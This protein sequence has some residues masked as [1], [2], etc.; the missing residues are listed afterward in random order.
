[1]STASFTRSEW[2]ALS[3]RDRIRA[4][5]DTLDHV[6]QVP[7]PKF[8]VG[9]IA[10]SEKAID[11][12]NTDLGNALQQEEPRVGSAVDE[13]QPSRRASVVDIWRKRESAP[14]KPAPRTTP[15]MEKATIFDNKSPFDSATF[16]DEKKEDELEYV[17]AQQYAMSIKDVWKER[18][19]VSSSSI[20]DVIKVQTPPWQMKALNHSLPTTGNVTPAP[21]PTE[22]S[23]TLQS[24]NAP[25]TPIAKRDV[26]QRADLE[27]TCA[28]SHGGSKAMC[29]TNAYKAEPVSDVISDSSLSFKSWHDLRSTDKPLNGSD[30][31]SDFPSTQIDAQPAHVSAMA[32]WR[33]RAS[34][35][36]QIQS[37]PSDVRDQANVATNT[38]PAENVT[39]KNVKKILVTEEVAKTKACPPPGNEKGESFRSM[40]TQSSSAFKTQRPF[41]AA[42]V[43]ETNACPPPGHEKGES[44]SS[45]TTQSSS[46]L[47][48]QRPFAA[49]PNDRA[50]RK[51]PSVLDRWLKPEKPIS[52]SDAESSLVDTCLKE[53][54]KTS[55]PLKADEILS[56]SRATSKQSLLASAADVNRI[57]GTSVKRSSSSRKRD[58]EK[59]MA[60][61]FCG[62]DAR[63]DLESLL[64][65][66]IASPDASSPQIIVNH[67]DRRVTA[68]SDAIHESSSTSQASVFKKWQL[69]AKANGIV[70]VAVPRAPIATQRWQREESE[71]TFDL[72]KPALALSAVSHS[73]TSAAAEQVHYNRSNPATPTSTRSISSSPAA[74]RLASFSGKMHN[75]IKGKKVLGAKSL[76]GAQTHDF[77]P[78]CA[79]PS[80]APTTKCQ[81]SCSIANND[82]VGACFD[83]QVPDASPAELIGERSLSSPMTPSLFVDVWDQSSPKAKTVKPARFSGLTRTQSITSSPITKSEIVETTSS[84]LNGGMVVSSKCSAFA[85]WN[86]PDDAPQQPSFMRPSS[87]RALK[88]ISKRSELVRLGRKHIVQH[89]YRLNSASAE[90]KRADRPHAPTT[91]ITSVEFSKTA[92][93]ST[94]SRKSA[95]MR[96]AIQNFEYLGKDIALDQKGAPFQRETP[97]QEN[98]ETPENDSRYL[99]GSTGTQCASPR[100][101][102]HEPDHLFDTEANGEQ[103]NG[104]RRTSQ[105][106]DHNEKKNLLKAQMRNKQTENAKAEA[107]AD[108]GL[109]CSQIPDSPV[110]K[111]EARLPKPCTTAKQSL[112]QVSQSEIATTPV[113]FSSTTRSILEHESDSRIMSPMS[114]PSDTNFSFLSESYSMASSLVGSQSLFS[115]TSSL[116]NRAGKVM[117]ERRRRQGCN[118]LNFYADESILKQQSSNML[119]PQSTDKH[120]G[121]NLPLSPKQAS[122]QQQ[123]LVGTPPQLRPYRVS[124][125]E[126]E[127]LKEEIRLTNR[128]NAASRYIESGENDNEVV[129]HADFA[130]GTL[131]YKDITNPARNHDGVSLG[132]GY[133]T[134]E[135]MESSFYSTL[136]SLETYT[137]MENSD[138]IIRSEL[139]THRSINTH[140]SRKGSARRSTRMPGPCEPAGVTS[141]EFISENATNVLACRSACEAFSFQQIVADLSGE[142]NALG[143]SRL[144]SSVNET[145]KQYMR[146]RTEQCSDLNPFEDEDV[147]IEIEYMGESLDDDEDEDDDPGENLGPCSPLDNA[148]R[149]ISSGDKTC[150][151][152]CHVED[153]VPSPRRKRRLVH[154]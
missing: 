48:T 24:P 79:P 23:V 17:E 38:Q 150:A 137:T 5:N 113:V 130:P 134:H 72:A 99:V 67:E 124:T 100:A 80:G 35:S 105:L 55:D 52:S 78:R 109:M 47:K 42:I 57:S 125:P 15:F 3:I 95:M 25:L 65:D 106:R 151:R 117:L 37:E 61:A 89:N 112:E 142:L 123:T 10:S 140:R 60:K 63:H 2:S 121:S 34:S 39:T 97:L 43:E 70:D 82:A 132:T 66:E 11:N 148:F 58:R 68:P 46:A 136:R 59:E 26:E 49:A 122:K 53:S 20:K 147:A 101:I 119:F 126:I 8:N 153:E 98:A 152:V 54:V 22:A 18:T 32:L 31:K 9:T 107:E 85:A 88:S 16:C 56:T 111:F 118:Q 116:A 108:A 28:S 149:T 4:M 64:S 154:G 145:M 92:P 87:P 62:S 120:N 14:T 83:A 91:S 12:I 76:T 30:E 51:R 33:M 6:E 36:R 102:A 115:G 141:D 29:K 146:G 93:T 27:I 139:D 77:V 75:R 135:T 41:A 45:M 103:R 127:Q 84:N 50:E 143:F 90:S 138:S 94:S 71:T 73:D 1:M 7:P 21:F 110:V 129:N 13:A 131:K 96:Q 114:D 81:S 44:F 128:Y 144:S 19:L 104:D 133:K 69:M 40:T 74:S 86:R